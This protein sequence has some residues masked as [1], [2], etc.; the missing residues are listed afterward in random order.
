GK[1]DLLIF[2]NPGK[3]EFHL[4]GGLFSGDDVQIAIYNTLGSNVFTQKLNKIND[5]GFDA[6]SLGD[7]IYFYLLTKPRGT[8]GNGKIIITH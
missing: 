2:P 7:G 5:Y 4:K 8:A 6:S 1:E 3:G